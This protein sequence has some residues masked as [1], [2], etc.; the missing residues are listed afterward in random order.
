MRFDKKH[1]GNYGMNYPDAYL[2]KLGFNDPN[3]LYFAWVDVR[4]QRWWPRICAPRIYI[5]KK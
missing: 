2:T 1:K 5:F 4:S 3:K